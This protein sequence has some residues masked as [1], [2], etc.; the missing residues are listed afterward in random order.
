MSDAVGGA[1]S[2]SSLREQLGPAAC[3]SADATV[4]QLGGGYREP[5]IEFVAD[6]RLSTATRTTSTRRCAVRTAA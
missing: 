3:C 5:V 1:D 4:D 6:P 2:L